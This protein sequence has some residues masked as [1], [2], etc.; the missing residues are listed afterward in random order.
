MC[1]VEEHF[2][3]REGF[4]APGF[5]GY[6]KN[7]E[8]KFIAAYQEGTRSPVLEYK[9][10]WRRVMGII[11]TNLNEFPTS[12]A[13]ATEGMAN[14]LEDWIN[15]QLRAVGLNIK[16]RAATE[17]KIYFNNP[18]GTK[19]SLRISFTNKLKSE[20]LFHVRRRKVMTS[21]KDLCAEVVSDHLEKVDDVE[22][23]EVPV[24][25][26]DEVLEAWRNDWSSRY[27]REN[28]RL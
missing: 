6:C 22:R 14:S 3:M 27:Y 18:L 28:V 26:Q 7:F 21:L 17:E 11:F 9:T 8:L 13:K 16:V 10:D 24:T 25:V 4:T 23:L 2:K 1:A 12:I 20:V 19:K 5:T 15:S